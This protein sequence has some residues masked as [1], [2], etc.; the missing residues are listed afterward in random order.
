MTHA[1]ITISRSE[2]R[3]LRVATIT[4]GIITV[5]PTV[6]PLKTIVAEAWEINAE[7]ERREKDS[8]G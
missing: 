2:A 8:R 5:A 7:I 3:M 4:V 6:I 1:E